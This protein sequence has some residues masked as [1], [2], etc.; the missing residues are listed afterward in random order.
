MRKAAKGSVIFDVVVRGTTQK[1]GS[2]AFTDQK[3]FKSDEKRKV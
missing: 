2:M 1:N 3:E